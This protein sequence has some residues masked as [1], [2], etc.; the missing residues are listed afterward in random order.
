MSTLVVGYDGT[1][2][3]RA[4][5]AEATALAQALGDGIV[6]VFAFEAPR[7]GGEAADLDA[8]IEARGR[9]LLTE[10]CGSL[11]DSGVPVDQRWLAL[12]PAEGLIAA[13]DE[14]DARMIV[15]GSYG[16]HVLKGA[17]VGS[18]PYRLVHLSQR[19]V[20][21]VRAPG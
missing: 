12:P 8:A 19:P 17:L 6:L 1:D 13:A 16:E 7:I 20:L 11:A 9:A 14:V 4:A 2:G 21:V 10:A 3:A 18:T 15:V 5:L